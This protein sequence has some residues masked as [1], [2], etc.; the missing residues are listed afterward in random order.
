MRGRLYHWVLTGYFLPFNGM[1]THPMV[2]KSLK[3]SWFGVQ[4]GC[5]P[6]IFHRRSKIHHGDLI[7]CGEKLSLPSRPLPSKNKLVD[8]SIELIYP[9]H[10]ITFH[11]IPLH[12]ITFHY[13]PLHS[14]TFHYIPLHSITF[15][16]IPLHSITFHYIPLHSITFH[17][18]PL[19]SIT[20]HYIPLHSINHKS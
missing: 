9:L 10:S 18:I 8:M 1:Y 16:Y 15:H 19:H 3:W 17:Y 14:I 4:W 5:K 6:D 7:A 2:Q 13:I 20:F 12:S 11:Y